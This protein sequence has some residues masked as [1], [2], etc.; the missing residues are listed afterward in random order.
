MKKLTFLSILFAAANILHAQKMDPSK[1]PGA[2]RNSFSNKYPGIEKIS[3]EKENGQYEASYTKDG[4]S[5]SA[6]F[7]SDGT[8]TE[9]EIDIKVDELPAPALNYMK[10]HYKGLEIKEASKITKA[11]GEINYEAAINGKDAIFDANGKFIKE[12]KD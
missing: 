9:S 7:K 12:V 11:S 4:Q 10:E 8:F 5:L 2:V 3:W 6:M 1:V